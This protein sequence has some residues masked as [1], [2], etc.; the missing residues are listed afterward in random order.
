MQILDY[1]HQKESPQTSAVDVLVIGASGLWPMDRGVRVHG[2]ELIRSLHEAGVRV[3][4]S[5][6][7]PTQNAPLWLQGLVH[8][9]PKAQP[10][11]VRSCLNSWSGIGS[12]MRRALA[13][14]QA[15]HPSHLAGLLPLAYELR[16][17]AVI[18]LG[19]HGPMLLKG[20]ERAHPHI[21]RIWYAGEE[22]T[23]YLGQ[24]LLRDPAQLWRPRLS[25]MAQFAGI[26]LLFARQLDAVL[27][28]DRGEARKL[29]WITS[30]K[31]SV[32]LK[33]GVDLKTYRPAAGASKPRS[34]VFWGRL[35]TEPNV[36]G[37]RWFVQHVWP[38]LKQ[39]GRDAT[40]RIVGHHPLPMVREL[41][42]IAGVQVVGPAEDLSQHVHDAAGVILPMRFAGGVQNTLLEA[43]AMGLPIFA[44][45][46]ATKGLDLPR[47]D[48]PIMRCDKPEQWIESIWRL[49]NDPAM[50]A[51]LG[52]EAQ[53]WVS[54]SH[55]WQDTGTRVIAML[56]QLVSA[57][58]RIVP[59]VPPALRAADQSTGL[60]PMREAA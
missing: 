53:Q 49:W 17:K 59:V 20:I 7:R 29:G 28:S 25:M 37:L 58:D 19:Q 9:W 50:A 46:A 41:G 4:V 32:T 54:R 22:P 35:D 18:A 16:P 5:T 34:L 51:R 36:H 52:H 1:L 6:M 40:L 2:C 45:S 47:H 23:S 3:A 26:Q 56:N 11:H 24:C 43:A 27:A 12:S 31:Q 10:M 60:T 38:T 48:E 55:T 44:S 30:A 39:R 42:A 21:K 14:G 57:E 8:P 13:Q 33:H 15:L